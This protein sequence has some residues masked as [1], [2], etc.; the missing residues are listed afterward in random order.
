MDMF[1]GGGF[2]IKVVVKGLGDSV[3]EKEVLNGG[4]DG[5]AKCD[6]GSDLSLKDDV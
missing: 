2:F 3:F 5:V 1:A 4:A 6:G